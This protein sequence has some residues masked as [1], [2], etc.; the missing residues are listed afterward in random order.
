M[1]KVFTDRPRKVQNFYWQ[2]AHHIG[3]GVSNFWQ[4]MYLP[5]PNA[6]PDLDLALSKARLDCRQDLHK[7]L[8][9]FCGA[10]KVWMTVQVEYELVNSLANKQPFKQYLSAAP[11]R[12]FKRDGTISAFTNP[13]VEYLWILTDGIREFN[14]KF[15][16][17]KS[18]I[19]LSKVLTFTLKIVMYAP[20]EGRGLQQLPNFLTKQKT[21]I[22]IQNND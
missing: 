4:I 1:A 9:E 22:N 10:A 3:D 8:L 14:A 12:M 5:L 20:L 19:R 6:A 2:L 7:Q 15:I 13:F 21:T 17:D 16:R 11:T 18:G